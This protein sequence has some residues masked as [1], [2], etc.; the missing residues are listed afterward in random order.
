ML[1]TDCTVNLKMSTELQTD[2]VRKYVMNTMKAY[3][4]IVFITV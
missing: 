3:C 1:E 4:F 2:T